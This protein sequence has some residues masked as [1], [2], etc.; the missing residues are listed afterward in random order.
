ME[1]QKFGVERR[2]LG[3]ERLA[4]ELVDDSGEMQR[5]GKRPLCP[6]FP[7]PGSRPRFLL[8]KN[9]P[10]PVYTA[11]LRVMFGLFVGESDSS[12]GVVGGRQWT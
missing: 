2:F 6:R 7:V 9:A 12:G 1:W 11:D 10:L 3:G 8:V 5:A 4:F